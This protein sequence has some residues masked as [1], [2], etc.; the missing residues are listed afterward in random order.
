MISNIIKCKHVRFFKTDK[1]GLIT[2]IPHS[3]PLHSLLKADCVSI[4]FVEQK[5][6]EKMET[7]TQHRVLNSN[8]DIRLCPVYTWAHTIHR[9]HQYKKS[10][11]DTTVNT[12][13]NP[14]TNKLVRITSKQARQHLR[15]TVRRFGASSLGIDEKR[16]GT[17][18][19]RTSCAMLLHLA[20]A[21]TSTIML[22][23]R[24]KSDAFLLYL[25]KQVKEFTAGV[26]DMMMS[27]ADTFFTIQHPHGKPK[28]EA[29]GNTKIFHADREDPMTCNVDS[30]TSHPRLNG[31]SSKNTSTANAQTHTPAFHL[32]G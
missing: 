13:L 11:E 18:S 27:Q 5:N 25:R 4:T 23:G 7:I 32:W 17:H 30:I 19:L 31:R 8:K 26:S 3:Q 29:P 2:P 21:K 15:D 28:I 9:I 20:H 10:T 22:L 6:N 16:V 12:F 14:D 24:W 1:T